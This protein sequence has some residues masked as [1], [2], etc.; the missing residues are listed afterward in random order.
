MNEAEL[1]ADALDVT[2][3]AQR[4]ALLEAACGGDLALRQ[5]VEHL[6]SLHEADREFLES[7]PG[8]LANE[9]TLSF[10]RQLA[11]TSPSK[12]VPTEPVSFDMS[13]PSEISLTFP[14]Y[15]V[16]H[17]IGRGGMG[18]VLKAHD[19]KLAR[20]VAI[21]VLA[22]QLAAHRGGT[23]IPARSSVGSDRSA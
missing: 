6:L 17:E 9:S 7:S 1:F 13:R 14:G 10:V 21:K 15:D 19:K 11:D 22:P 23:A 4:A 12:F 18:L 16:E 2:D 3:P 5:R 8:G 20:D